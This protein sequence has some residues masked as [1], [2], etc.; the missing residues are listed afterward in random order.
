MT[1]DRIKTHN[2]QTYFMIFIF[3]N[4]QHKKIVTSNFKTITINFISA[5]R[6]SWNQ[7]WDQVMWYLFSNNFSC[8]STILL[9]KKYIKADKNISRLPFLRRLRPN[10]RTLPI[11]LWRKILLE[12]IKAKFGSPIRIVYQTSIIVS[13][14]S[15]NVSLLRYVTCLFTNDRK[16]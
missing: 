12:A 1:V 11:F 7:E 14:G 13:L 8:K 4:D 16:T 3:R 10:N 5:N 2:F 15:W 9:T 6:T